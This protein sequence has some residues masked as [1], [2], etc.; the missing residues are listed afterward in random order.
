MTLDKDDIDAIAEAV[1]RKLT[2]PAGNKRTLSTEELTEL[3]I[4]ARRTGDY[5]VLR[6]YA[7]T[8]SLKESP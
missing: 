5:S 3:H 2:G 1:V 8:G 7:K 4:Q 6:R